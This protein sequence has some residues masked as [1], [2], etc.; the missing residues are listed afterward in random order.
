MFSDFVDRAPVI[1]GPARVC[2]GTGG[3]SPLS[4]SGDCSRPLKASLAQPA[5]QPVSRT[6]L[7][8]HYSDGFFCYFNV[9]VSR[10]C[11]KS[12]SDIYFSW[13]NLHL[14]TTNAA[15]ARA[16][17]GLQLPNL[18]I[19]IQS[20]NFTAQNSQKNT[21]DIAVWWQDALKGPSVCGD[22]GVARPLRLGDTAIGV[23]GYVC[24][25]ADYG[26]GAVTAA[27]DD[28]QTCCQTQTGGGA[29]IHLDA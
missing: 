13:L 18:R 23:S 26:F 12:Q 2:G 28:V 3:I 7:Q 4:C 29:F 17:G 5:R 20:P 22:S 21:S 27:A 16:G 6:D 11:S 25:S 8:R 24:G 10:F 19:I 14:L 1:R 9:T 15:P